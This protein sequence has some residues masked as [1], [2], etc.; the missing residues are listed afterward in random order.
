MNISTLNKIVEPNSLR[1]E[2]DTDTGITKYYFT[3]NG[4]RMEAQSDLMNKGL[5]GFALEGSALLALLNLDENGDPPS[6]NGE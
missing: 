1:A 4:G 6:D 5:Y 2:T 3:I